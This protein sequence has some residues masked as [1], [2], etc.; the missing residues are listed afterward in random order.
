MPDWN[1]HLLEGGGAQIREGPGDGG[2]G[3]MAARRQRA[4]M[5]GRSIGSKEGTSTVVERGR[6]QGEGKGVWWACHRWGW[7]GGG[8][9]GG[10]MGGRGS[11]GP[12]RMHPDLWAVLCATVEES[13]RVEGDGGKEAAVA[14]ASFDRVEWEGEIEKER[15][16]ESLDGR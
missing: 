16:R 10:K 13:A 11:V 3:A 2:G 12:V 4:G 9:G 8:V 5:G 15:E 6:G 14:A 1:S 7:R